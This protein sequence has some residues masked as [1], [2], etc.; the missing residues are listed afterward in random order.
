MR[1]TDTLDHA[2]AKIGAWVSDYNHRRP[3]SSLGYARR[4]N[5]RPIS[6]QQA[7]GCTTSTSS[8]IACCS[9]RA[10]G[11]TNKRDANCCSRK[12]QGQVKGVVRV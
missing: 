3:H 6:R 8:A 1:I 4:R 9:I 12:V 10:F 11:R 2:R 7:T 5:M